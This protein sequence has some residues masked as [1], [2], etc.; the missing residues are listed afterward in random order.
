M[1]LAKI[2]EENTFS[3]DSLYGIR[4]H[5]IQYFK[6]A[7]KLKVI[8]K[9]KEEVNKNQ[10]NEIKKAF[11]DEFKYFNEIEV[12]CYRDISGIKLKDICEKYWIDIINGV[13]T[14][15][16]F[17]KECLVNSKKEVIDENTL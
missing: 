8:V 14:Y 13:L 3:Q 16:P 15:I 9:S 2:L 11:F 7:N 4:V 6:K 17:C 10:I 12:I 1:E 5:R